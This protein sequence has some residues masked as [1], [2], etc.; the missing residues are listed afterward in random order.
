[1]EA[2]ELRL[3]LKKKWFEMTKAGIKTED[4]REINEYWWPRFVQCGQ[5]YNA[6]ANENDLLP[7]SQ[8]K[9]IMPKPFTINTM[10]LGYP[11]S[12]DK[13]RTL[14]LEH[15]G[16]EIREGNPEWGA[17]PGKLYFVIKHGKILK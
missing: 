11:K 8:W 2:K 13:E 15:L 17:E 14:K 16:I 3:S 12:V 7:V 9:M 4:Y 1:M 6:N 10:T 5:I